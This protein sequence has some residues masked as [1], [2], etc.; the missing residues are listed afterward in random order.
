MKK[1]NITKIFSNFISFQLI[2]LKTICSYYLHIKEA[3]ITDLCSS[4]QGMDL[5]TD[6]GCIKG[7]KDRDARKTVS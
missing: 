3:D 2:K 6:T 1:L 4:C 7:S 5:G